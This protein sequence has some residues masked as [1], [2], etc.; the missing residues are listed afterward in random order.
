MIFKMQNKNS[1]INRRKFIEG[2]GL[3]LGSYLLFNNFFGCEEEKQIVTVLEPVNTTTDYGNYEAFNGLTDSQGIVN[4]FNQD[5]ETISIKVTNNKGTPLFNM[6]VDYY[7]ADV[8]N[9]DTFITTTDSTHTY[10]P[11]L[12][13][14]V[15]ATPKLS[16]NKGLIEIVLSEIKNNVYTK[17]ARKIK[18]TDAFNY[19]KK[20]YLISIPGVKYVGE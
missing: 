20:D 6:K 12:E 3:A 19:Y 9:E 2:S 10:L 18:E 14:F 11:D 1:K 7:K 15:K 4:V 16:E 8:L 17:L 5:G 13:H